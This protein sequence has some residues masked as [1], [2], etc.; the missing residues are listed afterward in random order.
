MHG[1]PSELNIVLRQGNNIVATC[2][3]LVLAVWGEAS[4]ARPMRAIH[5]S[6]L[7]LL[8]LYP[9]VGHLAVINDTPKMPTAEAREVASTYNRQSQMTSI[10]VVLHGDGFWLS[11]ARGFLT[12]VLFAQRG[13]SKAKTQ[14][15]KDVS[16][17]LEWH[18]EWLDVDAPDSDVARISMNY[19]R[20]MVDEPRL[21]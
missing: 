8:R 20:S 9:R 18:K 12:A 6:H 19:L 1:P 2:Q 10:A 21:R 3:N 13:Q 7:E 11:A 17:A 4:T 15:F 5:Q 16:E 14:V